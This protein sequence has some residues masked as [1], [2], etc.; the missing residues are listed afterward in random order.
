MNSEA[1]TRFFW[2]FLGVCLLACGTKENADLILADG[3][4]HLLD[5]KQTVVEALA[6]REGVV[7][8]SGTSAEI[9]KRF[10]A[11]R[12]ENLNGAMVLPAFTD[13]H[14]HIQNLGHY[15][16]EVDLVGTKSYDEILEKI[17]ERARTAPKGSWIRGR[18][19]DQNDWDVKE[20]PTREKLDAITPDHFVKL[21]RV[22]GHALLVNRKVLDLA[23]IDKN[24]RPVRGGEI[25]R[26]ASDEPT[27]ILIDN[28]MLLLLSVT[29][30]YTFQEDS[31]ALELAMAECLKYGLAEVH[32]AGVDS[33]MVVLYK[34]FG[35]AGK[36][37][38][39][40]YAMLDGFQRP[41]LDEYFKKGP[42]KNL[43]DRHLTIASVKLYADG[44]L[45]SRGA[46]L[47]EPYSDQPN[48]S[49]L[50]V[51]TQARLEDLTALALRAGFQVNTHAIGDRGNRHALDAY[52]SALLKTRQYGLDKRLRIEHAQVVSSVD[53][54]RFAKLGVIASMQPTHCTSDMYWAEQRVGPERI[55]GAYA[56]QTFL[57][58]G[59]VIAAGSDAPV[60][61]CNPLWGVYAAVTRQDQR[62]W[63]EGGWRPEERLTMFQTLR[64]FTRDAAYAAFEESW[65]GTLE[66]G[67]A[68]DIVILNR[69]LTEG[70]PREIL[71]TEVLMTLV[72]G[73][74]V[75]RK[76]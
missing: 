64:T 43:F 67:K 27:G 46:A 31:L 30:P 3:R 57:K 34:T 70:S 14:L 49:G 23:K 8:A 71:T 53:I 32:D 11:T 19:W 37:K 1:R 56:W 35:K 17:R 22:D 41:L 60:E 36:L 52:Q 20:F 65:K 28:A 58:N 7:I 24:T 45:G 2:W 73:R 75:Y 59:V 76:H 39:R 29:P 63:P 10:V 13:A 38:F 62:G 21:E 16:L 61:S 18:G 6:V 25:V 40:I 47:L 44:A 26:D 69:D 15:L 4:I 74:I 54:P 66:N 51:M 9:K 48:T 42:E 55:R 72:G 12:L 68:A 50:E 5:D 33:A